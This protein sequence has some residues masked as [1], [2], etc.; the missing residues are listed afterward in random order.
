MKQRLVTS[1]IAL[2]TMAAL[3]TTVPASASARPLAPAAPAAATVAAPASC[4][5]SVANFRVL[6]LGKAVANDPVRLKTTCALKAP[7]TLVVTA[8]GG[9]KALGTL[10]W[11][12]SNGVVGNG[13]VGVIHAVARNYVPGHVYALPAQRVLSADGT[14]SYATAGG[15]F[16]AVALGQTK[17][18]S[19]TVDRATNTLHTTGQETVFSVAKLKVIKRGG[20]TVGYYRAGTTGAFKRD[21]MDPKIRNSSGGRVSWIIPVRCGTWQY[22]MVQPATKTLLAVS[23]NFA[24]SKRTC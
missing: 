16:V 18:T 17:F 19:V 10:A 3:G 21:T 22:R 11:A 15:R 24:Y 4:A 12:G 1:G 6:A 20:P 8:V 2:M 9:T 13:A 5:V 7:V 23:T 14:R